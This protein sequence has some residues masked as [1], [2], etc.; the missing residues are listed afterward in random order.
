MGHCEQRSS[1][2]FTIIELMI[3][4]SILAMVLLLTTIGI[5]RIGAGYYKGITQANTQQTARTILNDVAQ[6]IQF[7]GF[8]TV[9]DNGPLGH[10][11]GG[12]GGSYE[13]QSYCVGKQ[14][15]SYVLSYQQKTVITSVPN[16]TSQH[17]LWEDT[18]T[19]NTCGALN[20]GVDP[21]VPVVGSSIAGVPGSGAELIGNNMR[22][23]NFKIQQVGASQLYTISVT[24]IYGDDD[25]INKTGGV[26]NMSNWTCKSSTGLVGA[27]FCAKSAITTTVGKRLS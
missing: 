21:P 13:T 22:L 4:I 12:Y 2:G 17:V 20:T 25:L 1:Q 15:Y 26:P 5:V 8:T 19:D 10:N 11:V 14:R 16:S 9:G 7:S 24:V 23:T 3:A 6:N 18:T 27:S